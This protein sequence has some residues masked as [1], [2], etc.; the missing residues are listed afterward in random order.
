M[1]TIQGSRIEGF[2]CKMRIYIEISLK[3]LL[4]F[5]S[6]QADLQQQ[7]DTGTFLGSY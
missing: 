5:I 6:G 7:L 4:I 3:Y 2:H 1:F